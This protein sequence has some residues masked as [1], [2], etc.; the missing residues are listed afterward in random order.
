[1]VTTWALSRATHR[2]STSGTTTETLAPTPSAGILRYEPG[3]ANVSRTA[4]AQIGSNSTDVGAPVAAGATSWA[5]VG[6]HVPWASRYST[7]TAAMVPSVVVKPT[8]STA[9]AS[10]G[11]T[12]NVTSS[13]PALPDHVDQ[14]VAAL[15][16]HALAAGIVS[17]SVWWKLAETVVPSARHRSTTSSAPQTCTSEIDC[18]VFVAVVSRT[19]RAFVRG[20]PDTS[21]VATGATEAASC[22]RST[23]TSVVVQAPDASRYSAATVDGQVAPAPSL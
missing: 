8:R 19:R 22:A 7:S 15:P 3:V 1:M 5:V 18:H 2:A 13:R 4:D 9:R 14:E 23:R 6:C 17:H 11:S 12:V 21:S 10:A 20:R 16:S